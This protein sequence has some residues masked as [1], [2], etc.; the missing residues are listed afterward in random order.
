LDDIV[1]L[2]VSSFG[3]RDRRHKRAN[4]DKNEEV[5]EG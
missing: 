1:A 5:D 3:G 4:M 2:S